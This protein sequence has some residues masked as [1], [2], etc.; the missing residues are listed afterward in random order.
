MK[1]KPYEVPHRLE[2]VFKH[3]G[4]EPHKRKPEDV[5]KD[6]K[7]LMKREGRTIP[8][9]RDKGEFVYFI[10]N[11]RTNVYKVGVA[12][13]PEK[14]LA[15]LQTA[16]PEKLTIY[17]AFRCEDAYAVENGLHYRFH[18]QNVRGE[19]YH[20]SPDM[21]GKVGLMGNIASICAKHLH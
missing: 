10:R 16:N 11:G 12:R 3:L 7:L 21:A 18:A 20:L 9:P 6:L 2:H 17:R 8:R 4:I 1:N 15:E 5:A 13:D 14:R 19:W